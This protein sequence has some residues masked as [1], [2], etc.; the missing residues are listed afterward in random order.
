MADEAEHLPEVAVQVDVLAL[1]QLVR[2]YFQGTGTSLQ[3]YFRFPEMKNIRN[4]VHE[5]FRLDSSGTSSCGDWIAEGTLPIEEGDDGWI[6]LGAEHQELARI[7]VGRSGNKDYCAVPFGDY[8]S[9]SLLRATAAAVTVGAYAAMGTMMVSGA[10]LRRAALLAYSSPPRVPLPSAPLEERFVEESVQVDGHTWWFRVWL[11]P[12]LESFKQSPEGLPVFLLLHGFK[13]CGWDNWCQTQSGLAFHLLTNTKWASWFPGI[14]VMP[15]LPRRPW[16]ERWWQHWRAPAM[17]RMALACLKE[18]VAKYSANRRRLYLLGE[19]L[20]TEGAW[21]LAGAQPSLFAAVAGSC[22]SVEPYDWLSW[23][24]A[25]APEAYQPLARAISRSTPMW[26]CHGCL[27]D[28]VPIEQA[29]RFAAA[30]QEARAPS[31][32]LGAI[33]GGGDAAEVVFREYADLD[34]H[35]WDH[36]YEEDGLI[37][38]L[39]SH[40]KP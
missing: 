32:L 38:W 39:A 18:A 1:P 36:A 22:G 19:S 14:V 35:V 2:D 10:L 27:D 24:W 31:A 7:A 4:P 25:S 6:L 11:P 17:Q 28:F 26:F 15:Q 8:Y 13:E 9:G 23:E 37:E 40:S 30:L 5:Y 29:R 21:A 16:D 3:E 33:M 12:D 34:H 20:G